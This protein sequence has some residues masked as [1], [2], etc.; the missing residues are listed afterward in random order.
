M[1]L[2]DLILYH[3]DKTEQS[4]HVSNVYVHP[5]WNSDSISSGWVY[6]LSITASLL[7]TMHANNCHVYFSSS[8]VKN[9]F[10]TFSNDIALLKLSSPVSITSYVR[11]AYLPSFGEILPHNNI[12][13][14]TGYGRT[15]S[16]PLSHFC[17]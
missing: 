15:S 17:L 13:Y 8:F 9:C 11:T 4:R 6:L 3:N 5:E 2:G 7:S 16:E 10:C 14:L 12:C 1:V